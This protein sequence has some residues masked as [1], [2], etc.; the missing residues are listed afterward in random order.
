MSSKIITLNEWD[1]VDIDGR[2]F[3]VAELKDAII[4]SVIFNKWLHDNRESMEVE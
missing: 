2:I 3:R 4:D 1:I